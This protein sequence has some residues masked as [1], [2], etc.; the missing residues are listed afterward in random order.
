MF[1]TNCPGKLL[2]SHGFGYLLWH[3]CNDCL[4]LSKLLVASNF[5]HVIIFGWLFVAPCSMFRITRPLSI[6]TSHGGHM[7]TV[8]KEATSHIR[9]QDE[10]VVSS[11]VS[12]RV[13][14]G[15][16]ERGSWK[17]IPIIVYCPVPRHVIVRTSTG[18]LV[19]GNI[20]LRQSF[21][22]GRNVGGEDA[23]RENSRGGPDAADA[24]RDHDHL[25]TVGVDPSVAGEEAR[26]LV[27]H[28][29]LVGVHVIVTLPLDGVGHM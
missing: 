22:Q 5:P 27:V 28:L 21:G 4:D 8:A 3:Q 11:I 19:L 23:F 10:L 18:H 25:G 1:L 17:F 16:G 24:L 2:A 14:S 6:D 12:D 13:A 15:A 29:Q 7:I 9:L 20:R 26:G